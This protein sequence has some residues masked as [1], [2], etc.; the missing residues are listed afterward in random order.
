MPDDT[1][2]GRHRQGQLEVAGPYY[3]D[4]SAFNPEIVE[5]RREGWGFAVL[6]PPELVTTTVALVAPPC[7]DASDDEALEEEWLD[8]QGKFRL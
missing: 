5:L 3:L 1:W 7:L 6:E 8:A 4:G 2:L